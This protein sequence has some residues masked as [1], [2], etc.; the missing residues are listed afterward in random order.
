MQ[1]TLEVDAEALA[2]AAQELGTAGAEETINAAL[3]LVAGRRSRMEALLDDPFA[4]GTGP[5][6]ADDAVM[7]GS[8]R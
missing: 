8:R 5:D 7:R 1:T 4:I 2:Q 6:I 3:V